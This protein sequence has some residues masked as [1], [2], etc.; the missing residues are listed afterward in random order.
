MTGTRAIFIGSFSLTNLTWSSFYVRWFP[1]G[2]IFRWM[3][4]NPN[5]SVEDL[6]KACPQYRDAIIAWMTRWDEMLGDAIETMPEV[7]QYFSEQ[8]T[9]STQSLIGPQKLFTLLRRNT[10][11]CS[12]SGRSLFL[13]ER[14]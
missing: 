4:G 8:V 1:T 6:S 7:L 5:R 13:D 12:S 11:S 10:I 2:G 3:Q 14:K 9:N